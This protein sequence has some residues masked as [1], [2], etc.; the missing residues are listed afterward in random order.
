MSA[1]L[2][3]NPAAGGKN[4]RGLE[5]LRRLSGARAVRTA[6]LSDSV[7]L[8]TVLAELAVD[9][10]N[11]I[12]LSSGDGTLQALQTALVES[13]PF[14]TLPRLAVLAHGSTNLNAADI[15]MHV[16]NPERLAAMMTS[17]GYL[18][19]A[20]VVKKRATLR[21]A[22]PLNVG[23]QHGMFLG[24]GAIWKGTVYYQNAI[25]R[26]WI[27]GRAGVLITFLVTFARILVNRRD[28][29]DV[30]RVDQP[31]PMTVRADG[32]LVAGGDQLLFMATTLERMVLGAWPFR[33]HGNSPLKATA[34][35]YPSPSILRN[36]I[37][38]LYGT[39]GRRDIAGCQ[40]IDAS[41][42]E[43]TIASPFVIDG[44]FFEAPADEPLRI[45][46]GAEFEYLCG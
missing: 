18:R 22:N 37:P 31:F 20:T 23:P 35:S 2:I 16:R 26:A 6:V 43:L 41:S 32:E 13:S 14:K 10:V 46:I 7:S 28:P 36:I 1:A 40:T 42:I 12:F 27:R 34:I 38:I 44:E 5:L 45:G 33:E 17:D 39:D 9:G 15:G 3:V 8:P 19:R 25:E 29:E 11:T 4:E 30:E 24:A 21:V